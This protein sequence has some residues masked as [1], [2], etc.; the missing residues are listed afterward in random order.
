M[1]GVARLEPATEPTNTIKGFDGVPSKGASQ[2]PVTFSQAL[3]R[4]VT[5]W[6]DLPA[7]LKAVILTI[8]NAATNQEGQ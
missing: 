8:V 1:A 7:L 6:A 4:I 3:A 2:K 5:A